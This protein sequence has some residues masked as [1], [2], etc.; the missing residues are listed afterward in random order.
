MDNQ[1]V[2][3]REIASEFSGLIKEHQ[4]VLNWVGHNKKVLEIACH[5]GYVTAWLK[6]QKCDIVGADIYGPAL[7]KAKPYLSRSILGDIEEKEVWQQIETEK[8]DVVLY[9]HILEHLVN[10]EAILKKTKDILNPGGMVIICLPNVSNWCERWDMFMGK[11]T[12][13]DLGVMDRTHLHFY[14]YYTAKDFIERSNLKIDAYSGDS[15]KVRFSLLPQKGRYYFVNKLYNR[16]VHKY[17]SPNLTDKVLMY[18][19]TAG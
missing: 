8:Y 12:Y 5:T 18:K 11:F 1:L 9:M 13:T 15:W 7:E 3:D 2:Y 16:I 10:P 6:K 17:S 14:N 4:Q 19:L